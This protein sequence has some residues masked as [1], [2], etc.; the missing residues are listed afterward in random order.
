MILLTADK[1]RKEI[2]NEIKARKQ[3][4]TP[5]LAI[6]RI[7]ENPSDIAYEKSAIKNMEK[8]DFLV[9]TYSYPLDISNDDFI[10]EFTKINKNDTITAIL[11]LRPLPKHIDEAKICSM[12]DIDK[13]IDCINP[14]NI[15]KVFVDDY[16]GHL[17]CTAEAVMEIIRFYNIDIKGKNVVILG[18][19]MVIGKPLAMLMLKQDA[20]VSICHSKSLDI[21]KVSQT[22]DILVSCIGKARFIDET[23]IKEGA[24][25]ID[26]GINFDENS[27]IC[28]DI[29]FDKVKDKV[30]MITPVPN[31]VGG[32]TTSILA[33]HIYKSA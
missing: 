10:K 27:K 19:S 8:L 2:Y 6:V 26:V 7:G 16:S 14:I 20:T 22:A 24:I 9:E 1:V 18:R 21:K 32:V 28:G 13:D 25:L 29:C 4:I 30:S 33:K 12:I 11:L 17:P 3:D 15:Y 31:G 5:K 23:Y